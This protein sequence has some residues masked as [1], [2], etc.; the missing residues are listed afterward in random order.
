[1]SDGTDI[2]LTYMAD[3]I[4]KTTLYLD[5]E[6]YRR[7]K[8][9]ARARGVAP[10]MLVREAVAAYTAQHA[11]RR[12]P[13]SLGAGSSGIPDLGSRVDELLAHGFGGA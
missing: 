9:L 12:V 1:M 13:R 6:V 3:N 11:P 10:A 8:A 7:L 4:Q 5:A 2:W